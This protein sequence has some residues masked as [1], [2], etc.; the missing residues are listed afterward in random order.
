MQHI[1]AAEEKPHSQGGQ[2]QATFDQFKWAADGGIARGKTGYQVDRSRVGP[3]SAG[4][5]MVQVLIVVG[6]SQGCLGAGSAQGQAKGSQIVRDGAE[7]IEKE[8]SQNR[9]IITLPRRVT[10]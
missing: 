5:K 2:V 4:R 10:L 8:N 3:Q 7:H 6:A 9:P 1:G